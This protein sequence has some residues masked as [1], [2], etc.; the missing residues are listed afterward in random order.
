MELVA[1]YCFGDESRDAPKPALVKKFIGYVIKE[2]NK[3]EDFTPFDGQGID[4]TPVVRSFILQQL[5]THKGKYVQ[6][7]FKFRVLSVRPSVR[8]FVRSF[9][10][11]FVGMFI[12][13]LIY[14]NS[15]SQWVLRRKCKISIFTIYN[16]VS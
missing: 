8:S 10:Y 6:Y 3:T 16:E 2:D 15:C 12:N 9:V 13:S 7:F 1:V 11:L 4:T 14:F 5:L